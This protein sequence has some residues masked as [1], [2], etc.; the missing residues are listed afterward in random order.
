MWADKN[1]HSFELRVQLSTQGA[2]VTFGYLLGDLGQRENTSL[3]NVCVN[4]V[5]A[6]T[7]VLESIIGGE[8]RRLLVFNENT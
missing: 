6:L 5:K 3:R 1:V 7:R 2:L 4:S 8:G